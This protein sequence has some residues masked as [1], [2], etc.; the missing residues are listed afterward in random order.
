MKKR[1][2]FQSNMRRFLHLQPS[3]TYTDQTNWSYFTH[4]IKHPCSNFHLY[5]ILALL[6]SIST[7]FKTNSANKSHTRILMT[8]LLHILSYPVLTPT[9][10]NCLCTFPRVCNVLVLLS[11]HILSSSL[12]AVLDN[13]HF[14]VLKLK[15]LPCFTIF[16]IF[17]AYQYP[18]H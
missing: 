16:P 15:S 14:A 9:C 3:R 7:I 8:L 1:K 11:N 2:N 10:C 17:R 12:P 4:V 13:A 18:H 6:L 5:P